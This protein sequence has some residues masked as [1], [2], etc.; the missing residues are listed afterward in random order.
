ME[1]SVK[2]CCKYFVRNITIFLK[3]TLKFT[4]YDSEQSF[5]VGYHNS[6]CQCSLP[7]QLR[8]IENHVEAAPGSSVLLDSVMDLPK[9]KSS[10]AARCKG[11]LMQNTQ[12][13]SAL[14]IQNCLLTITSFRL[15]EGRQAADNK[16]LSKYRGRS[17]QS[18]D[19]SS[20]RSPLRN[21]TQD[22]NVHTTNIVEFRE[23][24]ASYRYKRNSV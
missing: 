2:S 24:L 21:T 16:G 11:V 15:A 5:I 9:K 13:N 10:R 19:K 4:I 23:P 12:L 18:P 3:F 22:S 8:H 6:F 7:L 20:S 14:K 17:Q 1:K